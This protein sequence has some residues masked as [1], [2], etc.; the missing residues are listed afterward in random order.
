MD[1][2][3]NVTPTPNELQAIRDK[4]IVKTSVIGILT[5]IFLVAFK[6][7]VGIFSNSIAVIL[8]AVNNLSDALS[9]VVT[10]AGAKL[11][12]KKPDKKHPLGYGRI[13][14]LSAMI[15]AAIVLYAG[16]TAGVESIKKIITP[17]EA[18]YSVLS[19]VII[20]VAVGVKVVLGLYVRAT[21]RRVNSVALKAS[22][23]DA[24]FDAILSFSVLIS[25]IIYV[26]TGVS[27]EAYVGVIIAVFIVKS[28]MGMLF[29]TLDEILGHRVEREYVREIKRTVCEDECVYGA[30]DLI[31]HSYGPNNYMGS[32]HV[33]IPDTMTADEIDLLERRITNNVYKKH[34]VMLTS[35]GIY[36]M[37][38]KDD[39]VK[40]M[41]SKIN[42]MVLSHEGVLQVHGFYLNK[43]TKIV[44]LDIILDFSV[45]DRDGTFSAIC[46][47]VQAAYPD[48]Q[49]I[50]TMDVDV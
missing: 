4:A 23:S 34:G 3:E 36:S 37:N 41:Q 50:A 33:E 16:I 42:K 6:A 7:T 1:G 5:N 49:F 15:V 17:E 22:G 21:G 28:G 40:A 12:G 47:E 11:A 48:Y 30:Y 10:I 2:N 20:G 26:F 45:E 44:N 31:L 29:E 38:T 8:D 43:A 18:D 27:L 25:A 35:I 32:I 46:Q 39:E 9:S 24:L 14:Y 19:L 13:E